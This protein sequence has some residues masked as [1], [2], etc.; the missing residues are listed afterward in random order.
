MAITMQI[1]QKEMGKMKKII[2]MTLS[3][4]FVLACTT[5][6]DAA[7]RLSIGTTGASSPFYGY[8]VA[9]AQLINDKID[10]TIANVV[11]TGATVDNLK[12]MKRG[13]IDFGLITTNT[14]NH[15]Y[16]GKGKFEGKSIKSK[17]LWVYFMCPQS[18]FVRVDSGVNNW[19]D[20]NDKPFNPGIRGSATEVTTE[21]VFNTLGIHPKYFRGSGPDYVAATKDNRIVGFTSSSMGNKL[22]IDAN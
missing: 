1:E 4:L 21:A 9:V 19:E 14:L 11:E 6:V 15:A 5:T 2:T 13:Q 8:Y 7:T 17:L 16:Y 18:T 10:D 12:R 3:A 20:L 22:S